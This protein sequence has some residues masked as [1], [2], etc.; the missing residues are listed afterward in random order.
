MVGVGVGGV[1]VGVGGVGVG[2]GVT[3]IATVAGLLVVARGG[4]ES[5][6]LCSDRA[7]IRRRPVL[8]D[9]RTGTNPGL[10]NPDR[11]YRC[12]VPVGVV[13]DELADRLPWLGCA[14]TV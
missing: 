5:V 3:V 9:R 14:T 8:R 1:G 10:S 7:E 2:V 13:V 12:S 6:R 4:S 11:A